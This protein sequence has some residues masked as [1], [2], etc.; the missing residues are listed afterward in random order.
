MWLAQ[1]AEYFYV[2]PEPEPEIEVTNNMDNLTE[3]EMYAKEMA[4]MEE[5]AKATA[6][7]MRDQAKTVIRL[8]APMRP[9]TMSM[10]DCVAW[11]IH[12]KPVFSYTRLV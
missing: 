12:R 11:T 4:S 5:E 2:E 1:V 3:V 6:E 10:F 8:S 7:K 9:K